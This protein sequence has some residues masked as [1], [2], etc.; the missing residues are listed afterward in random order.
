MRTALLFLALAALLFAVNAARGDG[1]V[2]TS[3]NSITAP[4]GQMI[5]SH[6]EV[7]KSVSDET[8]PSEKDLSKDF[9]Q[10]VLHGTLVGTFGL[11]FAI[12]LAI[13]VNK[14][15]NERRIEW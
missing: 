3:S 2:G 8:P 10:G 12:L 6:S 4:N 1:D 7:V 13:G 15:C 9:C 14:V 11:V 5:A